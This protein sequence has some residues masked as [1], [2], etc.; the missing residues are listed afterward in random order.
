MC[1]GPNPTRKQVHDPLLTPCTR[2]S[3]K[4]RAVGKGFLLLFL[5]QRT[6][7]S[8]HV[9]TAGTVSV[10]TGP[11]RE[12]PRGR[13]RDGLYSCTVRRASHRRARSGQHVADLEGVRVADL[14][15]LDGARRRPVHG[16]GEGRRHVDRLALGQEAAARAGELRGARVASRERPPRGGG[17]R[18]ARRARAAGGAPSRT[19][20]PCTRTASA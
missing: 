6:M 11:A 16:L 19:P 4:G 15:V 14:D 8:S 10:R 5:L 12:R 3:P 9:V 18:P 17:G 2:A 1:S 13:P 7:R 20:A